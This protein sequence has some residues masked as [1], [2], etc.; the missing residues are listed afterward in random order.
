MI[1]KIFNFGFPK[2]ATTSLNCALQE[3]GFKSIHNPKAFRKLAMQG[4]YHFDDDDWQ[5]LTNFGEHFYPQ[6][7]QAYPN[8][9]FILTIRDEELWLASWKKQIGQSSG[10][11]IGARWAWSRRVRTW[12][13][14][15]QRMT[16]ADIRF[17]HM[18]ARIDIFG[19]YRFHTERCLYVYR[20]HQKNA[21]DYFQERPQ[22]FLIMDICNG[23]GWETLCPFLEIDT[24]PDTPFPLQQPE[25]SPSA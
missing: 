14:A 8:S 23:D 3:L 19:T 4:Q 18:H 24:I 6:L 15:V 9:K 12:V 7:D 5:A 17:T 20:L 2:T 16:E 22:D 1:N 10:D 21:R 13:R 25:Q 11:E